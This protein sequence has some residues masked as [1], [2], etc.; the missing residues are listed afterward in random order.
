MKQ[1]ILL[2]Q[3]VCE[4]KAFPKSLLGEEKDTSLE[5]ILAEFNIDKDG[6]I[7]DKTIKENGK[8]YVKPHIIY[9]LN[10]GQETEQLFED[11]DTMNNTVT[12]ILHILQNKCI[13]IK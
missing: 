5:M 12:S 2:L 6:I 4:F 7:V 10:N 9:F 1:H 3:S 8:V 13:K 11:E